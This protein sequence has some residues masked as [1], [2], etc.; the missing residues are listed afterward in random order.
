MRP[1][2]AVMSLSLAIAPLAQADS[3]TDFLTTIS[4]EGLNV[5]DSPADVELALGTAVQVCRIL[6]LGDT[7]QEAGL[8]VPYR[9]P[10]AT[11]EQVA[12][13]VAAAQTTLCAQVFAPLEPGGSY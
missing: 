10:K 11:P 13:F 9:F 5:G 8:V 7:P 3:S 4:G 1:S 12:G 6:K 2:R